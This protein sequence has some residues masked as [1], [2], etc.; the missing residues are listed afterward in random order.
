MPKLLLFLVFCL[1]GRSMASKFA[2]TVC[3]ELSSLIPHKTLLSIHLTSQSSSYLCLS[4]LSSEPPLLLTLNHLLS[5]HARVIFSSAKTVTIFHHC[6][7]S[8]NGCLLNNVLFIKVLSSPSKY[9][10]TG[11]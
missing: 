2:K 9:C 3:L 7:I 8:F 4:F 6:C 10:I 11:N 5:V 1:N